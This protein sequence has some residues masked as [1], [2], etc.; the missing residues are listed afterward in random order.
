MKNR[1]AK[2]RGEVRYVS[3]VSDDEEW[4]GRGRSNDG[5]GKFSHQVINVSA[6]IAQST[7]RRGEGAQRKH[8]SE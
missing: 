2:R 3:G 8:D 1:H 6:A 4:T 7:F 5:R